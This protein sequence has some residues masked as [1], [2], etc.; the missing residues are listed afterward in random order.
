MRTGY[1]R[2]LVVVLA[3]GGWAIALFVVVLLPVSPTTQAVFYA[4]GFAGL[5]GSWAL[6]RE[7]YYLRRVTIEAASVPSAIGLLGSGMRF[8]A[9]VEFALWLQSLR[10]LTPVYVVLLIVSYLFLEYLFRSAE[11]RQEGFRP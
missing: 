3:L 9:G 8:A 4:A 5:A 10:M 7:L 11:G 2:G 6:L 1:S